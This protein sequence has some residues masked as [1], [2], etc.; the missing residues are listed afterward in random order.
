MNDELKPCP[1]CGG[2]AMMVNW[3]ADWVECSICHARSEAFT[4]YSSKEMAKEAWNRRV[5]SAPKQEPFS[6]C[7]CGKKRIPTIFVTSKGA[8]HYKRLC[9]CGRFAVGRTKKELKQHW[10]DMVKYV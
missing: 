10:N 1:F 9:N 4:V 8:Y 6:P 3:D 2:K 5:T 7:P